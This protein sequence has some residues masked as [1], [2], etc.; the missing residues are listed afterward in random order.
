MH[1]R[2]RLEALVPRR[3]ELEADHPVILRIAHPP[4]Q[5]G[6]HGPVDEPDSAVVSQLWCRSRR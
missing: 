4:D 1:F 5:L 2:K 3:G 6:G